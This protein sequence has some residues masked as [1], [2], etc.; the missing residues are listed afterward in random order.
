MSTIV[1]FHAHPDDESILCG[2]TLAKAAAEGHRVVVVTATRGEHGEVPDGF[3]SAGETLGQRREIELRYAA[4]ILGADRVELL[5]YIDSGMRDEPTNSAPGA[6]WGA[7]IDEAAGRL[8]KILIEEA[9]DALTIYDSHGAYGHPD[10]IQVHRVGIRAAEIAGTPFVFEATL[11]RE[12]IIEL[13]DSRR[14][15]QPA[16]PD[17]GDEIGLPAATI[18]T[19]IDVVDF[20]DTK[21]AAMTA[22]RS[23]MSDDSF[24]LAMSSDQFRIAF[25]TEWYRQL[26][27]NL[28]GRPRSANLLS[29]DC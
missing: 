27:M 21:R 2:G 9:S 12:H 18:T 29:D 22:H 23:Q 8:A 17:I 24:F 28:S 11:N 1:S 5:G 19:P 7:D 25:G 13:R 10:H 14:E 26:P 16:P 4:R 20:L 6:F 3:L 15:D